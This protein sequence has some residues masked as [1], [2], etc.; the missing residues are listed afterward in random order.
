MSRVLAIVI[1]L[2]T[3]EI[4]SSPQSKLW[5]LQTDGNTTVV[6]SL[7]VQPDH[8]SYRGQSNVAFNKRHVHLEA[9]RKKGGTRALKGSCCCMTVPI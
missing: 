6:E 2:P 1:V 9:G 7:L 8:H 5:I 4:R 3:D